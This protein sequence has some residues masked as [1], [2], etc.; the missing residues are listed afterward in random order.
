MDSRGKA[1]TRG[2]STSIGVTMAMQGLHDGGKVCEM[3]VQDLHSGFK[4]CEK[5]MQG[6]HSGLTC[7]LYTTQEAHDAGQ[8]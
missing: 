6:L 5:A 7:V 4:V 8:V 2:A 1:L 3:T